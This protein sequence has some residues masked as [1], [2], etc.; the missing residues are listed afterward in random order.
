MRC[1]CEWPSGS[2]FQSPHVCHEQQ[3]HT[4]NHRCI[5]GAEPGDATNDRRSID[6]PDTDDKDKS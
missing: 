4:T 3:Y 6:F 5:C 1:G 2:N